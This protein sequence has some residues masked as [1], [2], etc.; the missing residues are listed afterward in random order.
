M[1]VRIEIDTKTFYSILA[2]RNRIL[3]R[4]FCFMESEDALI[5]IFIAAF[6]ALA[7][8]QPV[9]SLSKILPGAKKSSWCNR[10]GLSNNCCSFRSIYLVYNSTDC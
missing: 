7:L 6:L 4:W 10:G 5:L 3:A 9:T 1:K 2:S 8:N